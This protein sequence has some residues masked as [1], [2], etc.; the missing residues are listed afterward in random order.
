[1]RKGIISWM[2]N[3]VTQWMGGHEQQSEVKWGMENREQPGSG[4][5]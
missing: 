1:M 3:T 2:A 4:G 5:G